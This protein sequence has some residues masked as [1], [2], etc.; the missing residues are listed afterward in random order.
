[1]P[2][3]PGRHEERSRSPGTGTGGGCAGEALTRRGRQDSSIA[4]IAGLFLFAASMFGA[5]IQIT[6]VVSEKEAGM[7]QAMKNFGLIDSLYW[8][9]WMVWE[10][11]IVAFSA[12]S[13]CVFGLVFQ[14][15]LF[16]NNSFG[17]TF[18]LFFLFML[19]MTS[20][21]FF[22][23]PLLK[24]R[25]G[26]DGFPAPPRPARPARVWRAADGGPGAPAVHRGVDH[27]GIRDFHRRVDLQHGGGRVRVP[28][29]RQCLLRE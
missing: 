21:A 5:V 2:D 11:G 12:L 29:Q 18:F 1:M 16:R 3:H 9:S 24:V 7:R 6:N 4:E 23:S 17:L 26:C 28:L 19:A 10:A 22:V 20:F 14:F 27:G 15:D 13:L 8:I 25:N